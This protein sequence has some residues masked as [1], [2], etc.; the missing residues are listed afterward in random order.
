MIVDLG[1][2]IALIAIVLL[3]LGLMVVLVLALS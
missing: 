1:R 2:R 3:V